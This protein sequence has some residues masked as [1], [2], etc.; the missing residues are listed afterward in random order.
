M[1]NQ[2]ENKSRNS[3]VTL[4]MVENRRSGGV[5][6]TELSGNLRIVVNFR[7]KYTRIYNNDAASDDYRKQVT[8]ELPWN[9]KYD[10]IDVHGDRVDSIE[11]Y[12][13]EVRE[14]LADLT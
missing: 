5:F 3:T 4:K 12:V 7:D 9:P 2:T 14:V 6:E 8:A 1:K 10:R 11:F 13:K